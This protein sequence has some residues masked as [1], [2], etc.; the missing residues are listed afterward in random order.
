[1]SV[2]WIRS[3]DEESDDEADDD[4]DEGDSDVLEVEVDPKED[5]EERVQSNVRDVLGVVKSRSML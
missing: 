2:E 4:V 5:S 1:M 3:D